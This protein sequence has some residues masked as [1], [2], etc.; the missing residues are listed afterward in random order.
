VYT[1]HPEH[2]RL[3][4]VLFVGFGLPKLPICN[5]SHILLY[6]GN[7][8]ITFASDMSEALNNKRWEQIGF[9][10][11]HER[12]CQ[13]LGQDVFARKMDTRQESISRIEAGTR[14]ID[15]L[16]LIE[17][18]EVLGYSITEIVWKIENYLSAQRLLPLPNRNVLDKKILVEVSWNGNRFSASVRDFIPGTFVFAGDTFAELRIAVEEGIDSHIKG[19]VA[20]GDKVPWWLTKKKYE[21]EYK[22]FDA[23]SLL[24]AYSPYVT[25]AAINRVTGINQN[26]LSQYAKGQK[27]ASS[28]QLKRIAEAIQKIGRELTAIVV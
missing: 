8:F 3:Q 27:N 24:N 20:N 9:L 15:I 6:F 7:I 28:T 13:K 17:Y 4:Y 5:L 19:M 22:F 26:L 12:I 11:Q 2:V 10:L 25:F 21:F 14:K 18:A 23:T 1:L 16:E